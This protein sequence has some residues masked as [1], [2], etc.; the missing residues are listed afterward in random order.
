MRLPD[1]ERSHLYRDMAPLTASMVKTAGPYN[2]ARESMIEVLRG[3]EFFS[4]LEVGCSIGTAIR[5]ISDEFNCLC[6]GLDFC[7]AAL[8]EARRINPELPF[9]LLDAEDLLTKPPRMHA[10]LILTCG[11]LMHCGPDLYRK[12]CQNILALNPR[13]IFHQ[14]IQGD[15]ELIEN[16]ETVNHFKRA[17]DYVKTYK[18]LGIPEANIRR[19]VF[20]S[21]AG[22]MNIIVEME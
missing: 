17:H 7:E 12:I 22:L 20:G 9:R 18:D 14:E 16:C 21:D 8:E 13:L 5:R 1:T 15:E 11:V 19:T 10:D 4:A 2:A 3:Y 6:A